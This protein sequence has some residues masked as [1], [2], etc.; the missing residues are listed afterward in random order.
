MIA[1]RT[2]YGKFIDERETLKTAI[3]ISRKGHDLPLRMCH[4]DSQ[5]RTYFA[6]SLMFESYLAQESLNAIEPHRYQSHPSVV[7]AFQHRVQPSRQAA[8]HSPRK[9]DTFADCPLI[10]LRSSDIGNG[11][12]LSQEYN[13]YSTDIVLVPCSV[14]TD[15]AT[16]GSA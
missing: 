7:H 14:D 5:H 3:S 13:S 12:C 9:W 11:E 1:P 16:E 6:S 10:F 4:L 15:I 8:L 2:L